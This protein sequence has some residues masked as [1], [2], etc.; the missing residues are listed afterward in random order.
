MFYRS[1]N[2]R[3]YILYISVMSLP[4]W[5]GRNRCT[6]WPKSLYTK[7]GN[8][9]DCL[10]SLW[11]LPFSIVKIVILFFFIYL[12]CCFFWS[13]IEKLIH[14]LPLVTPFEQLLN[15]YFGFHLDAN[16]PGCGWISTL[17]KRYSN[18]NYS[19]ILATLQITSYVHSRN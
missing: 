16:G 9:D 11:V 5:T 12:I 17:C 19:A 18:R 8:N 14:L 2:L 4:T 7:K 6:K 10:Q 3:Y 13:P 1:T 15:M